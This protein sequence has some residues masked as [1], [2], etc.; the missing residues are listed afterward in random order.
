MNY[1][2]VELSAIRAMQFAD[3]TKR[4]I[5]QIMRRAKEEQI[6]LDCLREE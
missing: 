1:T 3:E 4:T 6:A 2:L 5:E